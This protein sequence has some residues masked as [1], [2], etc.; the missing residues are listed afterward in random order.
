MDTAEAR[1]RIEK[2]FP[3]LASSGYRITS[4]QDVNYNCIAWA[5]DDAERRWD[6][7]EDYYWPDDVPRVD[8]VDALIKVYEG[9]GYAV[10]GNV[11]LESD[12]EKVAVYGDADGYTHAAK[13]LPDGKWTSKLGD[14]EDI[15]HLTIDG[16]VG[17]DYGQVR[18]ILK[19]KRIRA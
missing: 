18:C 2:W 14:A 15:E 11:D 10:C 6:T 4:P 8:S 9:L 5:A 19:R 3:V 17:K 12:Y 7:D 13:Q 1:D 16:L